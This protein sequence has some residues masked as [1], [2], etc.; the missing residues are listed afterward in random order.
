M[1]RDDFLNRP[2][3]HIGAQRTESDRVAYGCAVERQRVQRWGDLA[4][5]LIL[6]LLVIA[7]VAITLGAI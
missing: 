5:W 6:T 7:L 1:K 2:F 4:D 3:D